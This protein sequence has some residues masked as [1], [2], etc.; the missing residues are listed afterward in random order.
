MQKSILFFLLLLAPLSA[1]VYYGQEFPVSMDTTAFFEYYLDGV[2]P[3][4]NDKFVVI[5][6]TVTPNWSMIRTNAFSSQITLSETFPTPDL[7]LHSSSDY[8]QFSNFQINVLKDKYLLSFN[9]GSNSG[10]NKLGHQWVSLNNKPILDTFYNSITA[11]SLGL[12]H[13]RTLVFKD[14]KIATLFRQAGSSGVGGGN[15]YEILQADGTIHLNAR[16]IPGGIS[17][18]SP[19][20]MCPLASGNILL[21]WFSTTSSSYTEHLDIFNENGTIINSSSTSEFEIYKNGILELKNGGFVLCYK[22]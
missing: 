5:W 15:Y 17:I 4:P 21:N 22:R 12:A 8:W 16:I 19:R 2:A 20:Q 3:L 7:V 6:T 18:K 11:S 1:Q 14:N 13:T 10:N 9:H